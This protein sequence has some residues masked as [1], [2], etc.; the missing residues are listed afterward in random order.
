MNIKPMFC[1]QIIH[2]QNHGT[3]KCISNL[4]N[5]TITWQCSHLSFKKW[6]ISTKYFTPPWNIQRLKFVVQILHESKVGDTNFSL[7]F[8]TILNKRSFFNCCFN[9]KLRWEFYLKI[10]LLK[11]VASIND[12]DTSFLFMHAK[13]KMSVHL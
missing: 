2:L 6:T 12:N 7:V 3:S 5:L 9:G 4:K 13:F 8:S 11:N 1:K 10:N